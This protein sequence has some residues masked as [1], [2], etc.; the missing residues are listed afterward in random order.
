MR[1]SP[2][3]KA[4]DATSDGLNAAV[5]RR[6]EAQ[7]EAALMGGGACGGC[8]T[9]TSTSAP[10]L[11]IDTVARARSPRHGDSEGSER[12]GLRPASTHYAAEMELFR[13]VFTRRRSAQ[14]FLILDHGQYGA[15]GGCRGC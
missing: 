2:W 8:G 4:S 9:S 15:S 11:L 12:A 5:L 10:T 3:W 7:S 14:L 6:A 1:M 13:S